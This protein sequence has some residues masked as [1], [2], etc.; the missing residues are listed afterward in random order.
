[1]RSALNTWMID[2]R[3]NYLGDTTHPLLTS[4]VE[5]LKLLTTAEPIELLV[6]AEIDDS[7]TY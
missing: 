3:G 2:E 1:M 5:R 4:R 7:E 6:N